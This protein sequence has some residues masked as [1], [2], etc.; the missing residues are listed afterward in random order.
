MLFLCKLA[1]FKHNFHKKRK[2]VCIKTR[3]TSASRS[4]KGWDTKLTTVKWSVKKKIRLCVFTSS[5]KRHIKKFHVV[6]GLR[7]SKMCKKAWYTCR[8]VVWLIKSI[9]F[10]MFSMPLLSWLL[11]LPRINGTRQNKL[12]SCVFFK[13]PKSWWVTLGYTFLGQDWA[14][15]KPKYPQSSFLTLG[16]LKEKYNAILQKAKQSIMFLHLSIKKRVAR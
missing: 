1:F 13:A 12:L 11:K 14:E 9:G 5:I 3:S 2:E 15:R 8:V 6:V 4:L 16:A 7:A 10:L